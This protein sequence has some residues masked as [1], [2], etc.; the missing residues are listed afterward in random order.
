MA[1]NLRRMAESPQIPVNLALAGLHTT[2]FTSRQ[3][4]VLRTRLSIQ[5][6]RVRR[7]LAFSCRVFSIPGQFGSRQLPTA[8]QASSS[9]HGKGNHSMGI[10]PHFAL[11][12][13]FPEVKGRGGAL[14]AFPV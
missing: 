8:F 14:V 1:R 3:N 11:Y 5:E 4:S 12:V 7:T 2:T 10:Q 6:S 13:R 9:F